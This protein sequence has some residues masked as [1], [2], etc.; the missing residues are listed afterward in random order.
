MIA[1]SLFLARL[2]GTDLS[3]TQI[4]TLAV[5]SILLSFSVPGIPGGGILV[6]APLLSS[7]GIPVAGMGIL[8]AIDTV[9]DMFRT[10]TN[11]TGDIAAGAVLARMPEANAV[12]VAEDETMLR[13]PDEPR[14]VVS[15]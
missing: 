10:M 2:Y 5:G 8:L 1:G 11:V 6:M 12:P 13:A 3:P 15:R 14:P 7:V 4:A 9:P